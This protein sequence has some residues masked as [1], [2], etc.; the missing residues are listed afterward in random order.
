MRPTGLLEHALDLATAVVVSEKLTAV[1]L[2]QFLTRTSADK[3]CN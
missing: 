1:L 3:N 2:H